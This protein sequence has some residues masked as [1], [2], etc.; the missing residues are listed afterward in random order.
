[1]VSTA[2]TRRMVSSV[3]QSR[4]DGEAAGSGRGGGGSGTGGSGGGGGGHLGV[5]MDRNP[6]LAQWGGGAEASGHNL[7][8]G[9]PSSTSS[10]GGMGGTPLGMGISPD[11]EQLLRG[12]SHSVSAAAAGGSGLG[13]GKRQ[14]TSTEALQEVTAS[15]LTGSEIVQQVD[16]EL[17]AAAAAGEAGQAA[18]TAI[19]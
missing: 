5:D 12:G 17:A 15:R 7:M 16:R 14:R 4:V 18:E 1:M 10:G 6:S 9:L 2:Y 19:A 13:E 11:E 3:H 8:G